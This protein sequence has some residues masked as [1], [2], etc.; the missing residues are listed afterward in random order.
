MIRIKCE[1]KSPSRHSWLMRAN[2]TSPPKRSNPIVLILILATV[3]SVPLIKS[4][5]QPDQ[6]NAPL[7]RSMREAAMTSNR[8]RITLSMNLA[9][10]QRHR[11]DPRAEAVNTLLMAS[12]RLRR[13][14]GRS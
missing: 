13:S 12:A 9:I 11:L 5:M 2:Q 1:Q 6:R 7:L 10:D 8:Q 3:F 14:S 4:A